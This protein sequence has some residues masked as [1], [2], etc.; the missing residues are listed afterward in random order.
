MAT[1]CLPAGV[2]AVVGRR[3]GGNTSAAGDTTAVAPLLL[4]SLDVLCYDTADYSLN[5]LYG[6]TTAVD[7]KVFG[8][9]CPQLTLA[10]GVT[11][12]R[13]KFDGF[14]SLRLLCTPVPDTTL[15]ATAYT[16]QLPAVGQL[17]ALPAASPAGSTTQ[18][19]PYHYECP[20]G[21]K[22][23]SVLA[24]ID[25]TAIATGSAGADTSALLN[26]RFECDN[27]AP[28][29]SRP[30]LASIAAAAE[31]AASSPYSA[32]VLLAAT[33]TSSGAGAVTSGAGS[34]G[35][36]SGAAGGGGLRHWRIQFHWRPAPAT[37]VNT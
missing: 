30:S 14:T 26:L 7:D 22:V 1:S 35:S 11:L 18:Q 15:E 9:R 20:A 29:P 32:A 13:S 16:G 5:N 10:S 3:T 12:V 2:S 19:Q 33:G 24:R 27:A 8:E 25:S 17:P 36:S 23:V 31:L 37:V 28:D 6:G 21:S 34:G 4:A